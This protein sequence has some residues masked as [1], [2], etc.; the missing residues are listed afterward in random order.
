MK[1]KIHPDNRLPLIKKQ[2]MRG[3]NFEQSLA[4]YGKRSLTC[5]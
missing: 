3:T 1:G 2:K 4:E 5:R